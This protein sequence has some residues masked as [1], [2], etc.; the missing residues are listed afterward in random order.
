M[1]TSFQYKP[2]CQ[3]KKNSFKKIHLKI[4]TLKYWNYQ[5]VKGLSWFTFE[6]LK[7]KYLDLYLSTVEL[8]YL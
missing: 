4:E 3:K 1:F 6:R 8:R 7:I 5:D 2:F